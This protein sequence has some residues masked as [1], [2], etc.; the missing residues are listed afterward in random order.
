MA[1]YVS[2]RKGLRI[3]KKANPKRFAPMKGD[4]TK[5]HLYQGSGYGVL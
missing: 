4:I 5:D 3:V 2:E 1:K